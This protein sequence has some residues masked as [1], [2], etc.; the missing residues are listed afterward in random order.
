MIVSV[1]SPPKMSHIFPVPQDPLQTEQAYLV[2]DGETD[3]LF[4]CSLFPLGFQSS[5]S[6]E[7][8][9]SLEFAS[10]EE[11]A[12][13][14]SV[15][16][17]HLLVPV[18]V[19]L[20]D[21]E[22][23]DG[24]IASVH[25]AKLFASLSEGQVYRDTTLAGNVQFPTQLANKANPQ[26]SH[27]MSSNLDHLVRGEREA[28]VVQRH[29]GQF[30]EDVPGIGALQ[31]EHPHLLAPIF[32][33]DVE[34]GILNR[35]LN[36]GE[37]LI[38]GAASSSNVEA[39]AFKGRISAG[40]SCGADDG[41][42]EVGLDARALVEHARVDR[43]PLRP[44]HWSCEDPINSSL[45][46]WPCQV[47]LAKVGHVEETGCCAGGEALRSDVLLD[48]GMVEGVVELKALLVPVLLVLEVVVGA[49]PI[50]RLDW[51]GSVHCEPTRP[52][53]SKPFLINTACG[54]QDL[55]KRVLLH[56]SPRQ[57]FIVRED[58]GIVLGV[59]L[60]TPLVHPLPVL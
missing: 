60:V 40:A 7:V 12:L 57:S 58:H 13:Q 48:L 16:H 33:G 18:G 39:A 23:V 38:G 4:S 56:V 53:P 59:G 20:L 8:S 46:V 22:T 35:G 3:F 17:P 34:P 9:V 28:E 44:R 2:I 24:A 30:L 26:S 47:E 1:V 52:L 21:A 14:G 51:G 43:L 5:P 19:A 54:F 49:V 25:H 27:L 15:V 31:A 10:E 45:G 11:S 42:G 36:V 50:V 6:K 32:Q 55:M 37:V 29:L 41:D